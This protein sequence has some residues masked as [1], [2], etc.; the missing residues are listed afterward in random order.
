MTEVASAYTSSLPASDSSSPI[1]TVG[2]PENDDPSLLLLFSR[3]KS[4][5]LQTAKGTA[6]I[7]GKIE[8][9]FVLHN[10]RVFCR[11]GCHPL[12]LALLHGWSFDRP[13]LPERYLPKI[14]KAPGGVK[15]KTKGGVA[16]SA[17]ASSTVGTPL[18]E[19][20][21]ASTAS[22]RR[23]PSFGNG[24]GAT[25]PVATSPRSP[26]RMMS[27]SRMRRGSR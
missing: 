21:H 10:A 16:S 2:F 3:L 7:S 18:S 25:Y 15:G 4:R 8:F 9:D 27:Y 14:H 11:M 26:T 22:I 6:A 23:K 1:P 5:S 17:F 20:G 19:V 12:A 13:E 24:T